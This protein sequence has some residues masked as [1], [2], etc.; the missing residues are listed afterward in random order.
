MLA[1]CQKFITT[2][3]TLTFLCIQ[4]VLKSFKPATSYS[5]SIK[6]D[7]GQLWNLSFS[8]NGIYKGKLLRNRFAFKKVAA[9]PDEKHGWGIEVVGNQIAVTGNYSP[10]IYFFNKKTFKLERIIK[11]SVSELEDLAFDGKR[12]WVSSFREKKGKI[13]AV[14]LKKGK[15]VGSFM[16]PKQYQCTVIDGLAVQGKT[17]WIT[18]KHCANIYQVKNPYLP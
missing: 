9:I 16:L 10:R 17:I 13:Y 7:N 6:W 2:I 15:I 5:E 3:L 14:D 4:G 1:K 12:L 8:D 11:L 18:G